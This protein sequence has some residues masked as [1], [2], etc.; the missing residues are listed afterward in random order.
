[1]SERVDVTGAG[2]IAPG[3]SKVIEVGEKKIAVFN[4]DGSYYAIDDTCTHRGGPLSEGTREG[5]KITCPWHGAQFD[6]TDGKVLGGPAS[7][8]IGS[9]RVDISADR[10]H[11]EIPS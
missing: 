3:Q 4:V 8:G 11:I 6:L 1:M 10:I 7:K 5:T 9:Y 2:E